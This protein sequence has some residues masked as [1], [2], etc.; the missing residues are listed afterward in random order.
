M[1]ASFLG[2][3]AGVLKRSQLL[4]GPGAKWSGYDYSQALCGRGWSTRDL[5]LGENGLDVL[6][7]CHTN[8]NA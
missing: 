5:L 7:G 3:R 8:G 2:V 4:T 6:I 1:Y